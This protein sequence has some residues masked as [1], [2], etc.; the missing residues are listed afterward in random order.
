[1]HFLAHTDPR[2]SRGY[3]HGK[4]RHALVGAEALHDALTRDRDQDRDH[5]DPVH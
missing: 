5:A 3:I 1:M 2:V 4:R